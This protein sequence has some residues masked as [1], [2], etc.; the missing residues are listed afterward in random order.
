MGLKVFRIGICLWLLG[1][2]LYGQKIAVMDLRPLGYFDKEEIQVL[3]ERFRS[4]IVKT[5]K[6]EVMERQD[7]EQLDKELAL[8]LSSGFDANRVAEAGKKSGARYVILGSI[9]KI[10]TRY[11]IDVKLVDCETSRI[12]ESVAEDYR[13]DIEGLVKVMH[14]I[15]FQLAGIK[16]KSN[17]SKWVTAGVV[18][19][20]TAAII[21]LVKGQA[22]TP[23]G[24][25]MPPNPP[26]VP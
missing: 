22:T 15:A 16:E 24:L 9:G 19:A 21:M 7:M 25:P 8:Q 3:S 6:Y 4:E 14:K 2:V 11:T 13:G 26:S 12:E 18:S 23:S 20:G 17:T 5:K 1:A 10:G